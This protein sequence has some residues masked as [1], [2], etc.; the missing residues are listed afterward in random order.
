LLARSSALTPPL[1]PID[2][3]ECAYRTARAAAKVVSARAR[4]ETSTEVVAI[5]KASE[6]ILGVDD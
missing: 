1:P 6:V 4:L 5:I 3:Y 2:G